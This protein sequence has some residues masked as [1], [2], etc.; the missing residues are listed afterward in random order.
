MALAAG[1]IISQGCIPGTTT[2]K[3][4]VANGSGGTTITYENNSTQCGYIPPPI[5]GTVLLDRCIPDTYTRQIITADGQGGSTEENFPDSPDCGFVAGLIAD[6]AKITAADVKSLLVDDLNELFGDTH[7][8]IEPTDNTALQD[9]IKWGWGGA[10]VPQPER[11]QKI[12]AVYVNEIV[13]RINLSTLRTGSSDEEVVVVSRGNKILSNEFINEAA[14]LLATARASRNT[15]I[16]EHRSL[17]VISPEDGYRSGQGDTW[18]YQLEHIIHIDFGGYEK[19]RH[20]FNAGGDIGLSYVIIDGLDIESGVTGGNN[21]MSFEEWRQNIFKMGKVRLNIDNCLNSNNLGSSNN[22]GFAELLTTLQLLYTSPS[23]AGGA[24]GAYIGFGEFGGFS[25]YGSYDSS[26]LKIYGK[27]TSDGKLMLRTLLDHSGIS[28]SPNGIIRMDVETTQPENITSVDNIVTLEIPVP[29]ISYF[30]DWTEVIVPPMELVIDSGIS[31]IDNITSLGLIKISGVAVDG[32]WEYSIDSGVTWSASF[33]DSD[34]TFTLP[35]D[36]YAAGRIQLVLISAT[37][38]RGLPSAN[39]VEIIV[40]DES[41]SAP[42]FALATDSGSDASDGITNIGTVNVI[43][44]EDGATWQYSVDSGNEWGTSYSSSIT[45]FVLVPG[46]YASG[47]VQVRQIDVAGN[48]TIAPEQNSEA[49]TVDA[50][51]PTVPTNFTATAVSGS[52]IN[53]SWTA[54]TDNVGVTVHKVYRD[55]ILLATLENV[56]TYIDTGLT[57]VT[58]YSYT[59]SAGDAAGNYSAQSI[60][61]SAIT[62]DSVVPTVPT[63]FT[64]TAVSESQINLS[65]TASTDNVGVTRYQIRR[66]GILIITMS[67][68]IEYSDVGLV[69]TTLYSYTISAGDAAGNYSAQSIAA[70]ATTL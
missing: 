49:I 47:T 42:T 31:D 10:M 57:V 68:G 28:G 3:T 59:V 65:W 34:T 41:P 69:S 64:A 32:T 55:S 12:T 22:I 2:Y 43:G 35:P 39:A 40:D 37:G 45:T 24:G 44:V 18:K 14:R 70:I 38:I 66:G 6:K 26:K 60:A 53:L 25:A 5:L 33:T 58:S 7:A 15:V 4:V 9:A 27:I 61:A 46:T 52:Q 1:T 63:N 67:N 11:G 20:F 50:T 17:N 16:D 48:V 54:S 8:E 30:E 21:I 19:A 13:N 56:T 36:T 23:G 62:R 29:V 51:N